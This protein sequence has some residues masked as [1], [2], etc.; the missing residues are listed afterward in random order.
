MGVLPDGLALPLARLEPY[1]I[2]ILIGV[3][4]VLPLLGAQIGIDLNFVW[5]L[6]SRSTD[7]IIQV[8]EARR[9]VR[10]NPAGQR[11]LG[12]ESAAAIGRSCGDVL[13]CAVAGGHGEDHCPLAEVIA[14]GGAIG[15]RETAIRDARGTPIRIAGGYSRAP[16][17]PGG[18]IRATAILRD[19]SAVRDRVS[20]AGAGDRARASS[21]R[22][23]P[24]RG[25]A[26]PAGPASSQAWARDCIRLEPRP[27][28][29][30]YTRPAC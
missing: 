12:I 23:G 22:S 20:G 25:R 21:A 6:I 19:I 3:L 5:Q 1:G 18:P 14:S 9:V 16:A 15:Y 29:R 28:R 2:A 10:L 4:F 13:G 11:I 27:L 30:V 26:R 8:D 7:V 24:R 17:H